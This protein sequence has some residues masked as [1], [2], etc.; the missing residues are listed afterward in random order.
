[1]SN[2]EEIINQE[3]IRAI[4]EEFTGDQQLTELKFYLSS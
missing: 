2:L 1:M 3:Q 4:L